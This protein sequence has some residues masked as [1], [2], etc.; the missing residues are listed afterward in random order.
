M[1]PN[2]FRYAR[3]IIAFTIIMGSFGFLFILM[4]RAVPAA[5]KDTVNLAVGFILGLLTGVGAYYF[6][7]SKDKSDAD[8][9]NRDMSTTIIKPPSADPPKP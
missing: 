9:Q 3:H 5:N 7:S 8:A 2:I 6:G 1:T 4:Y